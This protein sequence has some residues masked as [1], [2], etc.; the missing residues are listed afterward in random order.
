MNEMNKLRSWMARA[1]AALT[2]ATAVLAF[3]AAPAMASPGGTRIDQR[4]QLQAQRIHQGVASTA[5]TPREIRHLQV[6]Q[7]HIARYEHDARADGW[8]SVHERQRL[9]AMQAAASRNIRHQKHDA[10]VRHWR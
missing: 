4:Q 3:T 10:Q 6:Q 9:H 8:L 1:L 7:R 5:L 2:A